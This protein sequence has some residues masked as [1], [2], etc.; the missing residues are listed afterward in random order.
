MASALGKWAFIIG[1]LLAVLLGILEGV[2]QALGTNAWLVLLLLV[3]GLVIGFVNI[4]AKEVQPFLVA[5]IAVLVAAGAANLV[6]ANTLFSPLGAILVAVVK[7]VVLV[8]APAALIVALR[9]V[10]G[11]AAE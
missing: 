2:G 8:V 11:F 4:A 6:A 3:L 1:A 10:Y 7:D 5:A 9:A